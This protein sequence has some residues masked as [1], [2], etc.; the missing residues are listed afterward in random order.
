MADILFVALISR[1]AKPLYM[2]MFNS[3]PKRLDPAVSVPGSAESVPNPVPIQES[4]ENRPK[5]DAGTFLKYNFLAHMALD[6]FA[7]PVALASR[8][9]L[10]DGVILLFVQDDVAVYGM[11][12]NS[13]L[14]I[15]VGTSD[16]MD[17]GALLR[18]FRRLHRAYVRTVCNPFSEVLNASDCENML[19][20]DSFDKKIREAISD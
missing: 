19:Q 6:I 20:T 5:N 2:Q 9:S 1:D 10:P 18:L 15:V 13:G 12:A 7:A 8:E 16:E 17:S 14:K 11:E 3:S 4:T